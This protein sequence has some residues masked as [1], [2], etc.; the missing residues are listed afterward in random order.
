[1]A[2][3]GL[4]E[5]AGG[6]VAERLPAASTVHSATKGEIDLFLGAAQVREQNG[7]IEIVN[8]ARSTAQDERDS[9]VGW[10]GDALPCMP[11][12]LIS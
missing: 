1:M 5:I 7:E 6:C 9:R 8:S 10:V 2:C 3:S 11:L 4:G 12:A